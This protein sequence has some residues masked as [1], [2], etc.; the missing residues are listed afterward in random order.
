MILHLLTLGALVASFLLIGKDDQRFMIFY[1]STAVL[2]L[3][4]IVYTVI[5]SRNSMRR[6]SKMNQHLESS[7]AEFMNS[8]PAPVAVIDDQRQFVWYNQIFSEKIGL[9]QDVYGLDFEGF[10]NIDIDSLISNGSAL[11]PVKGSIYNVTA[12][13]FEKN[14]MTIQ[15]IM[16]S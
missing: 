13:K 16:L 5:Y 10:V 2:I 8:L 7:A 12:E 1:I 4:G 15:I 3:V 14:D 11:C 6:I 9:G